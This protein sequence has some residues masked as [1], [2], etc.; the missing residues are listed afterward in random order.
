MG[1]DSEREEALWGG[2]RRTNVM[3]LPLLFLQNKG[4]NNCV[5]MREDRGGGGTRRTGWLVA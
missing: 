2:S 5:Q 4:L 3:S 1:V